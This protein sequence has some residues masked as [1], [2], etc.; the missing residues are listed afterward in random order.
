MA[1]HQ[2]C[3]IWHWRAKLGVEGKQCIHPIGVFIF[4]FFRN[5]P[6]W[7]LTGRRWIHPYTAISSLCL[8]GCCA[9]YLDFISNDL[10]TYTSSGNENFNVSIRIGQTTFNVPPFTSYL[11]TL[12]FGFHKHS[13]SCLHILLPIVSI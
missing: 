7:R 10:F 9:F 12:T 4:I 5:V 3:K 1:T 11:N 8:S 2:S 13:H 6:N